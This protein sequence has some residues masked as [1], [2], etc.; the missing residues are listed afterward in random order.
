MRGWIHH[1]KTGLRQFIDSKIM[2][3]KCLYSL[4]LYLFTQTHFLDRR[5]ALRFAS[6]LLPQLLTVMEHYT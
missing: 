2:V 5:D 6:P 1:L 4:E 3:G